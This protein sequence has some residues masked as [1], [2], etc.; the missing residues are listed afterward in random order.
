MTKTTQKSMVSLLGIPML[1][2]ANN[3]LYM[4]IPFLLYINDNMS[5]LQS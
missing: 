2:V 4:A 1:R 5:H 3:S